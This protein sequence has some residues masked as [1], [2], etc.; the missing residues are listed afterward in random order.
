MQLFIKYRSISQMYST[1]GLIYIRNT[2]IILNTGGSNLFYSINELM[3]Y[4]DSNLF[5]EYNKETLET[6]HCLKRLSQQEEFKDKFNSL[7][8]E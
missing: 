7:E 3:D 2:E 4:I 6:I 1:Y 5:L 8:N